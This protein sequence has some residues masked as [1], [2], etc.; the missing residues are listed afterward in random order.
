[1]FIV[2]LLPVLGY[3]YTKLY[4]SLQLNKPKATKKEKMITKYQKLL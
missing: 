1:M 4:Q 2:K 3:F